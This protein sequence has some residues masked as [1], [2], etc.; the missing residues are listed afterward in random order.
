MER[1]EGSCAFVPD[2]I[3]ALDVYSDEIELIAMYD[4]HENEGFVVL[5]EAVP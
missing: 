2:Q 5:E 3:F 1:G 4:G